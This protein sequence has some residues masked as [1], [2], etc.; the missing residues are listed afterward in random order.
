MARL[1]RLSLQLD[2]AQFIEVIAGNM[3]I[4]RRI[5]SLYIQFVDSSESQ[6]NIMRECI[7]SIAAFE[8]IRF[9]GFDLEHPLPIEDVEVMDVMNAAFVKLRGLHI[10]N[11]LWD[12][13]VSLLEATGP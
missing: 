12:D 4:R 8:D 1:R 6:P 2:D 10:S 7:N 9:L 13:S 5:Q 11:D 3:D